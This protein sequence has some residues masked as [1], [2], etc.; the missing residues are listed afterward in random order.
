MLGLDW[1]PIQHPVD[2][3]LFGVRTTAATKFATAIDVLMHTCN[4]T[5]RSGVIVTNDLGPHPFGAYVGASWLVIDY[6]FVKFAVPHSF[7][8][9]MLSKQLS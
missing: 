6:P 8:D 7:P 9:L 2:Q 3:Y 1:Q 4:L 5:A